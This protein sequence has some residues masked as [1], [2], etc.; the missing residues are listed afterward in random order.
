VHQTVCGRDFLLPH[1][2][3]GAVHMC[4]LFMVV[5]VCVCVCV[6]V[7]V[8]FMVICVCACVMLTWVSHID[9]TITYLCTQKYFFGADVCDI[10]DNM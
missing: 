2:L 4:V 6:R 7:Y 3:K 9:M 5:C 8:L 1:K 10:D